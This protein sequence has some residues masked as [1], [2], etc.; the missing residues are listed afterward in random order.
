MIILH[1]IQHGFELLFMFLVIK[2]QPILGSL[3][4]L[5]IIFYYLSMLKINVVD[6]KFGG[7]WKKFI[8]TVIKSIL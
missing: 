7:S 1:K 5:V 4:S 6:P 8:K 3:A 2:W